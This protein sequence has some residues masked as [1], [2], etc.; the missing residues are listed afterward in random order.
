MLGEFGSS[1]V[2][3]WAQRFIE[4]R[5]RKVCFLIDNR[6][7]SRFTISLKV[8]QM[9]MKWTLGVVLVC[10]IFGS[11]GIV[12]AQNKSDAISNPPK[13]ELDRQDEASI[14]LFDGTSLDQ[15]RGY[16]KEEIGGGWKIDGDVLKFDG[17]GG[18][19]IVTKE[20]FDNFELIFDWKVEQGANSGVMYRVSLG[21]GAPY[22]S[23]PEYQI[24]DD[25]VHADGKNPMTSAG[26]I[27]A[28]YAPEGKVLKAVGEWNSAKIVLN[29]NHLEHWLNGTCVAKTEINGDDWNERREKS[30]FKD[31]EKFG[32]NRSG[33]ICLQDHGNVVY[34]R[35]IKVKKLNAK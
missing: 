32:A 35:N 11:N 23:G 8:V 31:W 1:F 19:D 25:E 24:L 14:V 2:R 27:Y 17:S 13:A 3:H 9:K 28:M 33:H 20:T 15:W 10:L 6:H 26:S 29:G 18:G 16:Q 30:K 12:E 4:W 22:L 34:F 7:V 21:D 5:A